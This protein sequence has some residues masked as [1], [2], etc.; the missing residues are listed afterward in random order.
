MKLKEIALSY[1][2]DFSNKDIASL[3]GFFANDIVLRD[4]E[5]EA[6]GIESKG[7]GRFQLISGF[8]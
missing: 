5:I 1:F 6:E 3:R 4:W 2:R 8:N 7:A